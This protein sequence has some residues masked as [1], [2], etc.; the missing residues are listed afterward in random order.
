ME[1]TKKKKKSKL[2]LIKRFVPYYKKYKW[3]L[4]LD[5]FCAALTTLCELALPLLV[6]EI[7]SYVTEKTGDSFIVPEFVKLVLSCGLLYVILRL[8]DT[9]ANYYMATH[10]HIMGARIETDMRRDLFSH[11]NKLSFS[12]YDNTKIGTLMS[13]MTS[14]LFDVTEFSHHCP[15]EYFISSTKIIFAFIILANINLP[16]TLIVFASL[17][18]IGLC[19]AF[20]RKRMKQAFKDGREQTGIINSQIEDSLLG[21]RVVKSFANEELEKKKFGRGNDKF[22]KIKKRSYFYMGGFQSS[23]RLFDG[24][25]YIIVVVVGGLFLVW[26]GITIGDFEIK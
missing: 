5:L 19:L 16:L 10:G 25:M 23:T 18:L 20:F 21:M 17:P 26:D 13:R 14:D 1:E 4:A 7:T 8:I 9:L 11:L 12:Y 2:G 3:I 15:E 22:L 6:R 24:L